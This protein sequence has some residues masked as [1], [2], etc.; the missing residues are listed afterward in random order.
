MTTEK[1]SSLYCTIILRVKN[2]M[3]YYFK[4]IHPLHLWVHTHFLCVLKLYLPLN[5]SDNTEVHPE[6]VT[7]L[8]VCHWKRDLGG[9][10]SQGGPGRSWGAVGERPLCL[11]CKLH[12]TRGAV[13]LCHHYYA[14]RSRQGQVWRAGEPWAGEEWRYRHTF[15][16]VTS[17][18]LL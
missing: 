5:M 1:T 15:S 17:S 10:C 11:C 14:G 6:A 2:K 12:Q 13:P 4:H 7:R 8:P 16:Y 18:F 3:L 9:M